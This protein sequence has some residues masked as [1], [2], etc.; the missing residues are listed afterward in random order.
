MF[1]TEVY[2]I[3]SFLNQ[4]YELLFDQ[5]VHYIKSKY[6]V[7]EIIKSKESFSPDN[8]K[9]GNPPYEPFHRPDA[10]Y[11]QLNF[12]SKKSWTNDGGH[13]YCT[14]VLCD[15]SSILMNWD[16]HNNK[17]QY[18]KELDIKFFRKLKLNKL[19]QK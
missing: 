15:D 14:F 2:K 8:V 13:S 4:S 6:N 19:K 17:K 18:M 5:F 1:N 11:I 9:V 12:V 10:L 16:T 7:K 3:D